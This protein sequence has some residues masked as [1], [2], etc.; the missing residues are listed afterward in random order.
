LAISFNGGKDACVVLYLWLASVAAGAADAAKALSGQTVIF[1][2]SADEFPAVQS[3]VGFVKQSLGLRMLAVESSD[4]KRGMEDLVSSGLRA[5]VMG[6]RRGDPWMENVDVFSPSTAGWP[7]FMRI[8]PVI[9]WTYAHVW[10]FLRAFGLP[11]CAMYDD[12]Y[13]SIGSVNDTARNPELLRPDGSHAPAYKLV[14]ASTERAGRLSKKAGAPQATNGTAPPKNGKGC[15]DVSLQ[16]INGTAPPKNGK[17]CKDVSLQDVKSSPSLRAFKSAADSPAPRTAGIVVI[18]NEILNGKVHD[19]N[20][21]YLC[22]QLHGRGV[23]VKYVEVV[24]DDPEAIARVV[25]RMAER[26]D[27]VFTSGGLG[28]THDDMSMLGVALAFGEPLVEDTRFYNMLSSGAWRRPAESSRPEG[29]DSVSDGT[30]QMDRQT[31]DGGKEAARRKMAQLPRTARVEWLDDGNPWPLVSMRNV[32]ILAGMPTAFQRMFQRAAKDGRFDNV[33]RWVAESLWLDADEEEVLEVL[34]ETVDEF[35][36]VEIGSYPAVAAEGRR[37]LNISFE[38][39]DAAAVAAA[40]AR[41]VA[42]LPPGL[43]VADDD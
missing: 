33:R 42:A 21:H 27:F 26:C 14:D 2:D 15:K 3:F 24:S 22:G 7:A 11:Y 4:F 43:L 29:G 13:T 34:Q 32:Y 5:V 40:R 41:L 31:S 30:F 25:A 17:D 37:R 12:G 1:F 39:F 18:G 10:L 20:A 9:D 16:A 36:F 35:M 23:V 28:P 8:N 38:S 19:T 6:Q